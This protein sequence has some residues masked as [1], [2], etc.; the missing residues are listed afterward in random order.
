MFFSKG[1]S[2]KYTGQTKT[3]FEF[4]WQGPFYI[5]PLSSTAITITKPITAQKMVLNI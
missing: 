4:G 5:W 1:I 3:E 2:I